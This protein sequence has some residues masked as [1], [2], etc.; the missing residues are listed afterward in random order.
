MS[1]F[2]NRIKVIKFHHKTIET[3]FSNSPDYENIVN[4]PKPYKRLKLKLLLLLKFVDTLYPKIESS[5]FSLKVLP[6]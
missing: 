3:I 1:K 2:D 4:V 5:C 6:F